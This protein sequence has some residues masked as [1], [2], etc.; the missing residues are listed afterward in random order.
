MTRRRGG[1]PQDW[2][3]LENWRKYGSV[4]AGRIS[5]RTK[6]LG[7]ARIIDST[8]D[9]RLITRHSPLSTRPAFTLVELLVVITI[10]GILIALL[11]PA[12][13]AAREAA[14]RTQCANNIKQLSLAAL[15][16]ESQ[17]HYMPPGGWALP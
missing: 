17:F 5:D 8:R 11:L 14:R 16:F 13:Q 7:S 15:S 6:R 3:R 1:L 9:P 2:R 10:I 12:V 4:H